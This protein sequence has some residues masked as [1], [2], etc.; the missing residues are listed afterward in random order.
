LAA[1]ATIS[2]RWIAVPGV[3]ST[4]QRVTFEEREAAREGK[5]NEW[6]RWSHA[7]IDIRGGT[8]TDHLPR[9]PR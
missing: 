5:A 4:Y 6:V 8:P 3:P 2:F 1:I 9:R 7:R